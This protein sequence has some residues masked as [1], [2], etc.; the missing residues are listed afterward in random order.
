MLGSAGTGKTSILNSYHG[1][2]RVDNPTIGIDVSSKLIYRN[3][4]FNER[5][6]VRFFDMAG[7]RH[8]WQWIHDYLKDTDIVFVFYDITDPNT[9]SEANEIIEIIATHKNQFRIILVG[10]KTDKENERQVSI[11]QVN[12]FIQQWRFKSLLITHIETNK[13][14]ITSFKK[15]LERVVLGLRKMHKQISTESHKISNWSDYIFNWT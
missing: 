5:Q 15:I 6:S 4:V 8:W 9:L 3:G 7:A 14:N 11:F 1:I 13:T 2:V 10:N 12:R